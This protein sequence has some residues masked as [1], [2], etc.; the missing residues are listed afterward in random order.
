MNCLFCKKTFYLAL[1]MAVAVTV[2]SAADTETDLEGA[3]IALA[4]AETAYADAEA[5]YAEAEKNYTN[6]EEALA[7]AKAA[8]TDAQTALADAQ[9]VLDEAKEAYI[10]AQEALAAEKADPE[11]AELAEEEVTGII[12]ADAPEPVLEEPEGTLEKEETVLAE[13]EADQTGT[14]KE[15]PDSVRF[16]DYFL[17]SQRLLALA[18]EAYDAGDY[19][20]AADYA[21]EAARLARLSDEYIAET[22]VTDG[23]FPLPATYTVRGWGASGDC[24][25]NIAGRPWVYGDPHRWRVLYEANKSK[26]PKPGNPNVI[27]P[28]TVLDIPSIKGETRQGEWQPGRTYSPLN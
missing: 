12:I 18:R 14:E 25:W 28:G 3:R 17:E 10:S 20:A 27:D 8:F 24:F 1:F 16:N 26:L 15:I 13:T 6:A 9:A 11:E 5:A 19:D 7:N 22:D 2:Q 23:T 4:E 21:E